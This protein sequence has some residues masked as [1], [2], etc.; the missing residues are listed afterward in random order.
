MTTDCPP[1]P[2]S[3]IL[4][5]GRARSIVI[6]L[7]LNLALPYGAYLLLRQAGQSET[8]ALVLSALLPAL[9]AMASL[10]QRRRVNMLSLLVIGTTGLS[11]LATALSGVSWFVLVRPSFITGA[12]ALAFAGSLATARPALFYLARDTVCPTEA[13]ARG[14]EALW[15]HA[16]FRRMMRRLTLVWAGFLAAEAALRCVLAW[17]WPNPNLVAATQILWIVLPALLVRWSIRAGRNW[18]SAA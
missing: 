12:L 17:I 9:V 6:D 16:G 15:V 1:M 3:P 7:V 2:S 14:F 5:S 8:R 11:L 10:L 4:P 13:D 18:R